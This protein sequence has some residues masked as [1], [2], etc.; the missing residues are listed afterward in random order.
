MPPERSLVD[1]SRRPDTRVGYVAIDGEGMYALYAPA[2]K[3]HT[4][5]WHGPGDWRCKCGVALSGGPYGTGQ[6]AARDIMKYHR[7]DL[8]MSRKY[9]EIEKGPQRP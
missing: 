2:V 3:G 1:L 8:W 7:L 5:V 9:A 4:P 6:R